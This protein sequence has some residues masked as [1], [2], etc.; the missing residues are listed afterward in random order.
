M[1]KRLLALLLSVTL[2]LGNLPFQA[3][4]RAESAEETETSQYSFATQD[5]GLFFYA[6]TGRADNYDGNAD[7]QISNEEMLAETQAVLQSGY[8]NTI[9]ASPGTTDESLAHFMSVIELCKQYNC[10]FWV[11]DSKW[12]SD[13][14]SLDYYLQ[15]KDAIV[16]RIKSVDGAWDL[17]LGFN[18]DEPFLGRMT[19][20]EFREMT[21]YLYLK[22][23]KR[24]FPILGTSVLN[25][26]LIALDNLSGV[27]APTAYGLEYVTDIGWDNYAYDVRESAESDPQQNSRLA[28]LSNALGVTLT[29]ADDFYRYLHDQTMQK[30]NHPVNVWFLPCAY[31][32][33]PWTGEAVDEAYCIAHLNYFN[34]LLT[35][36]TAQYANQRSGGIGLF[37]YDSSTFVGLVK[38]LPIYVNGNLICTEEAYSTKWTSLSDAIKTVKTTFDND[39]TNEIFTGFSN[40]Y[41]YGLDGTASYAV[42]V[43][44]TSSVVGNLFFQWTTTGP[45]LNLRHE[46]NESFYVIDSSKTKLSTDVSTQFYTLNRPGVPDD[47]DLSKVTALAL[48]IKI[49]DNSPEFEHNVSSF[50]VHLDA[51]DNDATTLNEPG[52]QAR[53]NTNTALWLDLDDASVTKMYPTNGYTN[54]VSYE[55]TGSM[56]GYMIIPFELFG[57]SANSSQIKNYLR[58][59]KIFFNETAATADSKASTWEDKEFLLGDCFFVENID[60]FATS[61]TAG[62]TK[63]ASQYDDG[64]YYAQKIPGYKS[65]YGAG[66][67]GTMYIRPEF[68]KNK[69]APETSASGGGYLH[70]TK[71]AGGDRALEVSANSGYSTSLSLDFRNYD[72]YDGNNV[73]GTYANATGGIPTAIKNLG[74]KGLAIRAAITGNENKTSYFT[75]ILAAGYYSLTKAGQKV[76][77]IDYATGEITEYTIATYSGGGTGIEVTGNVD[78]YFVIPDLTATYWNGGAYSGSQ[79]GFSGVGIRLYGDWSQGQ[80]FF[81]GDSFWLTDIDKFKQTHSAP[82]YSVV[83]NE[84]SIIATTEDTSVVF[85][86]DGENYSENGSFTGL[87]YYKEY[88]LYAKRAGGRIISTQSLWTVAEGTTITDSAFSYYDVPTPDANSYITMVQYR[89]TG[90]LR[91]TFARKSYGGEY[92]T[93]YNLFVDRIG[94]EG[95][96]C[97]DANEAA[98]GTCENI[99][100]YTNGFRD[101]AQTVVDIKDRVYAEGLTHMAMRVK[102]S[103]GTSGQLSSFGLIFQPLTFENDLSDAFLIDYESGQV[104]DPGWS[105]KGFSFT[106]EFDGWIVF[107]FTAYSGKTINGEVLTAKDVI[108]GLTENTPTTS[109]T[110]S[111]FQFW[112]HNGGTSHGVSSESSWANRVLHF[113]DVMVL[114]NPELFASYHLNNINN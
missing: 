102:I 35:E 68:A 40:P 76:P 73:D 34:N 110:A 44:K 59:V 20:E 57:L 45:S 92:A 83:A 5:R 101:N 52:A 47:I 14:E 65:S 109:N 69:V 80:K 71:I 114:S 67:S 81:F 96:I 32:A 60:S 62:T 90:S 15:K 105:G 26:Q 97:F 51:T 33:G 50:R 112:F 49:N 37:T 84:N 41:S 12:N 89:Q 64:A 78:G 11:Y 13:S 56:N 21:K 43:P 38:R 48:R 30:F 3:F 27:E 53:N 39:T 95:M 22:Y 24:I 61:C 106:D 17:F 25:E 104:I 31:N 100:L 46:N 10:K 111:S 75:P 66:Y 113:G 98:M 28:T 87:D 79:A 29:T 19:N 9:F 107:P 94:D 8:V 99:M 88:T 55:T 93:G 4:V 23:Q 7:G 63:Y 58:S 108:L 74:I 85:S 70:I 103:G 18:W 54:A 72:T 6:F 1:K 36:T 42:M 86:L 77:F 16:S 91:N 2:M 82:E